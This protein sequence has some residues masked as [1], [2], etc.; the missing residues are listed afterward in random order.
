MR[1]EPSGNRDIPYIFEECV[2]GGAVPKNFFPAVEKGVEESVQK[3]LLAGYPVVGL[4]AVLKDGAAHSVDSSENAFKTAAVL[5]F[6]EAYMAA[7]P[8]LLEPIAAVKIYVPAQYTGDV[9]GDLKTR[10]ARVLGMVPENNGDSYVEADVPMSELDGYLAKL[11]SI[12][13]GYGHFEYTFSRYGQAPEQIVKQL[14]L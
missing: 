4:R 12:S 8:I 3:G 7:K 13:G 14:A 5:A 2:V 6:K 9:V 11:R 10:R 1:F